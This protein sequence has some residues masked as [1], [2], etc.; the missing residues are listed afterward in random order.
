MFNNADLKFEDVADKDGQL[1]PL[2]QGTYSKYMESEDRVLRKNAYNEVY[3]AY[4]QF[5]NT[6][7]QTLGG[8]VK[9][10]LFSSKV[11]NYDSPRQQAL[12]NNDIPEAVYDNPIKRFTIICRYYIVIQNCVKNCSA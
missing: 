12:S 2:S 6:L 5:N 4:G 10:A 8:K 7:S 1:H 11:R 9:S 3:R